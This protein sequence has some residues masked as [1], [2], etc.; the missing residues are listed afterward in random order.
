MEVLSGFEATAARALKP[1][2]RRELLTQ[3]ILSLEN[4]DVW[5]TTGS[6]DF[7]VDELLDFSNE[8]DESVEEED[9]KDSSSV[10][11]S[12]DTAVDVDDNNSNSSH[13]DFHFLTIDQ[14]VEPVN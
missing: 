3:Q 11:S 7:S 10:S 8:G 14:F 4:V 12:L 2:L 1:S 6:E 5:C 13:E 9:E